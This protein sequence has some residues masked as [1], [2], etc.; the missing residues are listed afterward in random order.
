MVVDRSKVLRNKIREHIQERVEARGLGAN[1]AFHKRDLNYA[2]CGLVKMWPVDTGCG[3]DLVSKRE[4]ALTKRFVEKARH[5][6]LLSTRRM[7]PR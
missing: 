2:K 3:Y 6:Q 7:A 4:V 1:P 5:T